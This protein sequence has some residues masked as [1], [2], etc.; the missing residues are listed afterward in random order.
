MNGDFPNS[1]AVFSLGLGG[2]NTSTI[3]AGTGGAGAGKATFADVRLVKTL[4]DCTPPLLTALATGQHLATV[5]ISVVNPATGTS[6]MTRILEIL[7]EN[8]FISGDEFAE[9][10]GGRPSEV[11]TLAW[12]KITV[13]HVPSGAKFTWNK[14]L[15]GTF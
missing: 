4:D 1:S 10:V 9:A 6:P 13:T 15:N 14:V 5:K 3:A 12:E 11:V 8:V 2:T 7:L